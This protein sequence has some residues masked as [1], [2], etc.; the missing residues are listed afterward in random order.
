MDKLGKYGC[1]NCNGEGLDVM[2]QHCTRGHSWLVTRLEFTLY[3]GKLPMPCPV[4][5]RR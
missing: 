2:E 4:C 5:V 3:K 1:P